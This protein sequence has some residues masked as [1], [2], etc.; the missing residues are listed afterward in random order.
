M[1][2]ISDLVAL[3]SNIIKTKN[4]VMFLNC[5]LTKLYKEW[6]FRKSLSLY[7]PVIIDDKKQP[8][9]NG[10]FK[11]IEI[12]NFQ[13]FYHLKLKKVFIIIGIV[14]I[15][16][17][18]ALLVFS[19]LT[20]F[21]DKFRGC[22]FGIIIDNVD[23]FVTVHLFTILPL[24]IMYYSTS[25]SIFRM[26]I[27]T[28]I[29]IH[30]NHHTNSYSILFLTNFICTIGFALGVHFMQL[31]KLTPP[32][33]TEEKVENN[34][35]A[36]ETIKDNTN[37]TILESEY[38]FEAADIKVLQTVM[39]FFP[40]ILIALIAIHYFSV[41]KKLLG[42]MGFPTFGGDTDESKEVESDG[43]HYLEKVDKERSG[44]SVLEIKE[45][46]IEAV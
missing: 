15:L 42:C 17:F 21:I 13:K 36:N 2:K 31:I 37:K 9:D 6:K 28:F 27:S 22:V 29:G 16:S 3:N 25:F 41:F 35:F 7:Q 11:P 4:N 34:L 44:N 5:Q 33:K 8:L 20:F 23:S 43:R 46:P 39:K 10:N 18:D 24:V 32:T 12:S 30:G 26:K 38:G 45:E 19:E 1:Q 14:L 40:L